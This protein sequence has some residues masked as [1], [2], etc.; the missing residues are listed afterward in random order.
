M[1]L[2]L[3]S[4]FYVIHHLNFVRIYENIY[5]WSDKQLNYVDPTDPMASQIHTGHKSIDYLSLFVSSFFFSFLFS[6]IF[7]FVIDGCD[8]M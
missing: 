4:I 5:I 8:V 2:V 6:F 7:N 3:I 1:N